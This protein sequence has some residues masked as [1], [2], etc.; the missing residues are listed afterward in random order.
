MGWLYVRDSAFNMEL[1]DH[2]LFSNWIH[3]AECCWSSE[4]K[5]LWTG[6]IRF[7]FRRIITDEKYN[8]IDISGG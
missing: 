1:K 2:I 7:V 4:K 6:K 3:D 8:R 5:Y